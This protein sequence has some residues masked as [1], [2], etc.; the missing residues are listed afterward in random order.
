MAT[1]TDEEKAQKLT[2][3]VETP[4]SEDEPQ[5]TE[6]ESTN[7]EEEA[8][9]ESE[10]E[11]EKP[12]ETEEEST[13]TKQFQNLKG[14][15]WEEYGQELEKAYQNSTAEAIRLKKQLDDNAQ[16]VER[17]RALLENS[18]AKPE[19]KA[20][21]DISS[22]P[23]IQMLRAE[24][25]SKTVEAFDAFAKKYPQARDFIGTQEGLDKFGQVSQKV[26]EAFMALHGR[27]PTYPE[28]FEKTAQQFDW[29]PSDKNAKKDAAI[30]ESA[31]EGNTTN[32]A[33]KPKP[34]TNITEAQ[35]E[36]ARKF[37]PDKK[38]SELVKELSQ[39]IN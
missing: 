21:F 13:F 14:D 4:K 23:E 36:M 6:E 5:E 15:S 33:P 29:Q 27:I 31:V 25:Q 2:E 1:L 39:T 11:E 30:K 37:F 7:Q 38:D 26:S 32:S 22:L 10:V 19:D 20:Q 12:A 16:L 34:K 17:A 28:L 18:E 3:G 35:L 9:E 8:P 24:Q